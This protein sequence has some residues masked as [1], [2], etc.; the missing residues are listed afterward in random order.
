MRG[1]GSAAHVPTLAFIILMRRGSEGGDLKLPQCL[2]VV[3]LSGLYLY[4]IYYSKEASHW[5]WRPIITSLP[6]I[7]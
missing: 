1:G 2:A 7:C 3:I 4:G 6:R 5:G